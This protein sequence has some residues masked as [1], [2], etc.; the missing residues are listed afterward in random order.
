LQNQSEQFENN[1][2]L[3]G[4][5][6]ADDALNIPRNLNL[7]SFDNSSQ[8]VHKR[9]TNDRSEVEITTDKLLNLK[10]SVKQQN[11]EKKLTTSFS[12]IIGNQREIVIS[13]YKNIRLN[14]SEMTDEL[15]LET[16]ATLTGINPKSLKNT[17]FR[18]TSAG[19]IIRADQK[20]G[21]GGWVKYQI[22]SEIIEQIQQADFLSFTKIKR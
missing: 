20:I 4:V 14:K 16:I 21:R 11:H 17:L 1:P 2:S 7:G 22:N 10:S 9:F 6:N 3:D 12:K 13:L 5:S 19:V 18:L 8:T 15:T